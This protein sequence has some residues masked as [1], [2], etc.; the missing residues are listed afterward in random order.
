MQQEKKNKKSKTKNRFKGGNAYQDKKKK[1]MR[2]RARVKAT[3]SKNLN[4]TVNL[5]DVF[6]VLFLLDI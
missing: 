2:E 3:F 5:S 6:L 1:E 4:P